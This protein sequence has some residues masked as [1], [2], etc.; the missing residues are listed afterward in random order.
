MRVPFCLLILSAPLAAQVVPDAT[1]LSGGP[2]TVSEY[3]LPAAIDPVVST[4]LAT[5]L[6]ARV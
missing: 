6:W 1:L 2:V 3:K 5:K 4:A